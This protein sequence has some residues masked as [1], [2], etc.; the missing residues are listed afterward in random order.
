MD[1]GSELLGD[2]GHAEQGLIVPL[3]IEQVESAAR[4]LARAFQD[5]P[6]QSVIFP[7]PARRAEALPLSFESLIYAAAASGGHLT[8]TRDGKA[9]AVWAPPGK[10][11]SVRAKLRGLNA[12][13]LRLIKYIPGS[14]LAAKFTLTRLPARRKSHMP[15]PHWYLTALGV[16]P[17]S[18]GRGL[19]ALL[20]REGLSRA[21]ADRVGAYLET[22]TESNVRF[23]QRFGFEVVEQLE[24]KRLGVPVWLMARRP[25]KPTM[26]VLH[27]GQAGSP[28][29]TLTTVSQ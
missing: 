6:I 12:R 7:D 16:D 21:D 25:R 2:P 15:D 13:T 26:P 20:V 23:Y 10:D 9:A 14:S 11:M 28:V 27:A 22:E 8:T 1:Q 24:P 18:Q 29:S 17:D 4:M 19:G 5:D 3:D